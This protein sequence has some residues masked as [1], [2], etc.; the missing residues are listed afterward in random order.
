MI[1]L[2]LIFLL[3]YSVAL[4]GFGYIACKKD[5]EKLWTNPTGK[6]YQGAK[7]LH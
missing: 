2:E 5:H 7:W 3:L 6:S 1:I 4:F